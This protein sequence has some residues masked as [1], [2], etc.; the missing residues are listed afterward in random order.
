M[1]VKTLNLYWIYQRLDRSI[2]KRK[3]SSSQN[4][5]DIKIKMTA[6]FTKKKKKNYDND[7]KY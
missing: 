6:I 5:N 2:F 3:P 7:I 4:I 1:D